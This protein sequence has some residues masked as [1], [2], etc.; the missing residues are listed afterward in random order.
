MP[1]YVIFSQHVPI[2]G[3]R[4][5][6]GTNAVLFHCLGLQRR[7][8]RPAII[9]SNDRYNKRSDDV[10]AIP[11]TSNP[12]PSEYSMPVTSR[13]MEYGEL[14][15]DSNARIDKIFS[16]EKR[17]IVRRIGRIDKKTHTAMR[18]L[19]FVLAK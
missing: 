17:I 3:K 15:V 18:K 7:K 10:V 16:V 2:I 11:L 19:L 13:D 8:S 12:M 4:W 9:I 14:V 1:T 5:C 6:T